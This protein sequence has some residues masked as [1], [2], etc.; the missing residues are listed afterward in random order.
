[1]SNVTFPAAVRPEWLRLG[2]WESGLQLIF[3]KHISN[4]V[5]T[6][7]NNERLATLETNCRRGVD[8][9][10]NIPTNIPN[11]GKKLD[12][13]ISRYWMTDNIER[14]GG[15]GGGGGGDGGRKEDLN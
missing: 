8:R 4:I 1:M 6:N 12:I 14:G 15:G 10:A 9:Q 11:A 13:H 2:A 5:Y 7:L 3:S